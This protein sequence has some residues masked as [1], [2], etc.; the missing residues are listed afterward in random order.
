MET[1]VARQPILDQQQQVYGYEFIFRSSW[2]NVFTHV[3]PNQASATVMTDGLSLL[4]ME[5]L[6]N[7]KK[8]FINIPHDIQPN[9]RRT[10]CKWPVCPA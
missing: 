9:F 3:D 2:E 6:T 5:T 4:G 10:Q 1:F 8:A 7:Q